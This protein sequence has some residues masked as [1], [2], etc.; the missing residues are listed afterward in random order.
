MEG[1]VK[2][3]IR[4]VITAQG[5]REEMRQTGRGLLR[6]D[7]DGYHLRYSATD[8][9]GERSN[10]AL[11]MTG[12]GITVHNTSTGYT[13]QLNP[14]RATVLRLQAGGSVLEMGIETRRVHWAL[15][16]DEQGEIAMDYTMLSGG[17]PISDVCLRMKIEKEYKE[18]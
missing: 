1:H 13:L 18:R 8:E 10:N 14:E 9:A 2:V 7:E 15:D 17:T 11:K 12:E 4:S 5:E 3:T 16:G 6:H